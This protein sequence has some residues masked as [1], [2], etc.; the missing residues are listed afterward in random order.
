MRSSVLRG[1]SSNKEKYGLQASPKEAVRGLVLRA[2]VHV[3]RSRSREERVKRRLSH[4][5]NSILARRRG[6]LRLSVTVKESPS[7]A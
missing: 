7:P 2:A 1:S 6:F 3:S 4:F 5:N